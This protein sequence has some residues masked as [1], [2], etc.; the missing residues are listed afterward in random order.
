MDNDDKQVGQ[1]LN[2]RDA[3]K[4]LG[5]GSAAAV[6]AACAPELASR[7]FV[8]DFCCTRHTSCNRSHRNQHLTSSLRSAPRV[9]RRPV[10]CG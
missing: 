1:I 10:F 9:D 4:I 2:R 7:D 6:L 8:T 3:L 5:L